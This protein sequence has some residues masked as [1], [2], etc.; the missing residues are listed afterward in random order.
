MLNIPL[1]HE[2]INDFILT[3]PTEDYHVHIE[4]D[5]KQRPYLGLSGL[6]GDYTK[7][8]CL[9]ATW[10]NWRHCVKPTFPSQTLRLFRDGDRFEYE[11]VWL[12]R[13]IGFE[14]WDVDS[15][16]KQFSVKDYENH[17]KGNSDGVA[18]APAHFWLD[19]YEPQP[20]LLEFKT[21]NDANF[22]KVEKEGVAAKY[23]RYYDQMI[24]YQGYLKLNL[25]LFVIK[26]KNNSALYFEN[27]LSKPSRFRQLVELAGDV[28]SGARVR[29]FGS[30][31]GA[32][33]M[34]FVTKEKAH[35][36]FVGRVNLPH[37]LK[38]VGG[39]ARRD[40]NT[41]WFAKI[42]RTLR[43]NFAFLRRIKLT[44]KWMR[45]MIAPTRIMKTHETKLGTAFN[46]DCFEV[47][48]LMPDGCVDMILCD[49]PYGVTQNRWDS[50]IPFE[51]MW[52]EFWRICKPNAAVVLTAAQPFTS[53][54]VMSQVEKF[55]Y[56][57]TWKKSKITGVL[58]AKKQP[59]RN[60][61]DII[62]FYQ[63]PTTYNPQGL[64]RKG[65]VTKQGGNSDN[66][67]KRSVNDYVQEWTNYPR[68]ILEIPSEGKGFHPTQKPVALFEYLIKTYTNEGD[69]VFD[70]TAG[71]LTTAVAAE[72]LNRRW[73]VCE[74]DEGYFDKGVERL[75]DEVK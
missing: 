64:V 8:H 70:P 24:S 3:N 51:P 71:S 60:K 7:E 26:N 49:P 73:A 31:A 1:I 19:G 20:F 36:R 16:G 43:N 15:E 17:V 52:A 44:I 48:K 68:S 67:G 37:P 45:G 65:T 74:M 58:N 34:E 53:A 41:V 38:T 35:K 13:G 54:L 75:T 55:K 10:M 46:A 42:G 2:A 22:K 5:D 72:A 6:G 56:D 39:I 66:Y 57:W 62:V 47:M 63:K 28:I 40:M 27:V 4:K 11:I 61:E 23:P 12:L 9:K 25:G 69:L 32:S 30:V 29:V 33:F 50:V 59:V 21:G 18:T 14:V